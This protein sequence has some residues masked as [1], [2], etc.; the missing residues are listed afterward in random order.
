MLGRR[1]L[2]IAPLRTQ[3]RHASFTKRV[4]ALRHRGTEAFTSGPAAANMAGCCGRTMNTSIP[5]DCSAIYTCC[6]KCD[7]T[8]PFQIP[9]P[10]NATM[11]VCNTCRLM[12]VK[13]INIPQNG[14]SPISSSLS[15]ITTLISISPPPLTPSTT[16]TDSF[17]PKH[18]AVIADRPSTRAARFVFCA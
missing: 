4:E 16:R 1:R 11:H 3:R 6:Y 15:N 14:T 17:S 13:M 2:C 10:R 7:T 18:R 8:P 12:I 9:I 5:S